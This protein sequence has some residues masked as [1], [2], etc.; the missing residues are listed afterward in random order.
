[1]TDEKTKARRSG[2]RARVAVLALGLWLG[3]VA[4][5]A[6]AVS[7]LGPPAPA[8]KVDGAVTSLR[9][10]DEARDAFARAEAEVQ[11]VLGTGVSSSEPAPPPGVEPGG[12]PSPTATHDQ[13]THASLEERCELACRA[14]GSMAR[15]AERLCELTGEDDDR[16]RDVRVRVELARVLVH[17]ICPACAE[18]R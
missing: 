5:G 11:G 10:V 4:L 15:S 1:M 16:C 14:L 18:A 2:L 9:T 8:P 7:K 13:T 12:H 3:P 6:C 17:G